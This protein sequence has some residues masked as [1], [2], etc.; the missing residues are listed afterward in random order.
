MDLELL[1][2]PLFRVP[3]IAGVLVSLILP[4]LGTLLR[5]RDEWLA[6]LGLAH[7]A[8]AAGLAGLAI[9]VPVVLGAPVGAA[10]GAVAKVML[11]SR[12]NT[13]YALMILLGWSTTFLVAANSALGSALSHT[14][15]DGQL[16]F[17]D[18]SHLTGALLLL[19]AVL[20]SFRWLERR[21]IRAQFFPQYEAANRLPAWRWHLTFD[22]LVALGMAIGT[23]TVGLMGAFALV[24]V[25]PWIAF[26]AAPGW[27]FALAISAMVGVLS[28]L[29]AFVIA[30]A[31]DQPFGP[32]LVATLLISAVAFAVPWQLTGHRLLASANNRAEAKRNARADAPIESAPR[33]TL[34][35][36]ASKPHSTVS[37]DVN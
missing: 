13:A 18:W 1:F 10:L 8:A 30:L 7:L 9:G 16:Y 21:L 20:A 35:I 6:A 25:P 31:L 33:S 2:D 36:A 19:T 32:V 5:L 17:A 34:S 28:Y 24:F 26:R 3:L 15:V 12:G 11:G 4:L 37:R 27:R 23:A 29:V 22:L 14:L